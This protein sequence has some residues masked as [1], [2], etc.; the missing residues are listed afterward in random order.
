[1]SKIK[2]AIYARVSST[3]QADE[4]IPI[5]GQLEECQRYAA[6]QGYEITNV[7]KDEGLTG[8]NERRPGFQDMMSAVRSKKC[9][10]EKIIVWR[11]NRIARNALNRLALESGLATHGVELISL[12]E[13]KFEGS[14]RVLMLPIMAGIDEYFSAITGEDT[15]RGMKVLARQ[16]FSA[17]GR[18]PKGYRIVRRTIGLKHDGSP[19][20]RSTWEPDPDWKEKALKA[21]EM[22]AAGASSESIIQETGIVSNKS[23]LSTYFR[24]RCFIGERV[25]NTQ[26]RKGERRVR[27]KPDDPDII[28]TPNAHPAIIPLDLFNQVQAMLIRR[29]P[30][31]GR[32]R[33]VRND[34][35]LT[36]VLWCERHN[37]AMTGFG[38]STRH[39]YA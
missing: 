23:S 33:D 14:T 22:M 1:M 16:G 30:R 10:F 4:E 37:C 25:F 3:M 6:S 35:I 27:A 13:P 24:N 38:N 39:Y 26:R 2:A 29:Q 32:I 34:F 36:G 17:G 18:P 5:T 21:F 12:N 9:P 7:F 11:G 28:R 15:L 31:P 19:L 8:K 20:L